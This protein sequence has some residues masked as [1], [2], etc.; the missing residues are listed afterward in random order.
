MK[1]K[2]VVLL[3]VIVIIAAAIGALLFCFRDYLAALRAGTTHTPEELDGMM[4]DVRSS[5]EEYIETVPDV[6]V[7]QPTQQEKEELL[8][9]AVDE[10][11]LIERLI[12]EAAPEESSGPTGQESAVAAGTSGTAETA[13]ERYSRELSAL[14]AKVYVLR[15]EY[16]GYL[17]GLEAQARS[18]YASMTSEDRAALDLAKWA[19]GYVKRA[20]ELEKQCDASMDEIA[21][22][23]KKLINENGKDSDILDRLISGYAEEKTLKKSWYLAKFKESGIN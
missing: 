21:V 22:Q 2:T 23:M 14:V 9:G 6:K 19:A 18:D 11:E 10:E 5:V 7:R 1:R 4:A 8:K 12:E 17:E 20:T 13:E 16:N 3:L 15:E